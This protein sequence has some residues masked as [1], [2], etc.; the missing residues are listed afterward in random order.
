MD[1]ASANAAAGRL[2]ERCDRLAEFSDGPVG[3]TR[4]FLSPAMVRANMAL[5]DWMHAAGMEVRQDAAG[6]LIGRLRSA[7]P[8]AKVLLVGSHLDTV[9]NAGRYDGI[10]GVLAGLSLAEHFAGRPLPFHLDVV[11]FSEEEGVRF[12]TPYL[13]SAAV[14]GTFDPAWMQLQDGDGFTVEDVLLSAGLEPDQIPAA[15]YPSHG[16]LGFLELHI[17]QGP[18]LEG[19]ELPLGVV[20]AIIGQ[21]RL[22]LRFVGRSGHAGTTPMQGRR[23]AGVAAAQWVGRVRQYGGAVEGLRATIGRLNFFPGAR[24]VIPDHVEASLDVRHRSDGIRRR[25]VEDLLGEARHIAA[26]EGCTLE[27]LER[28]HQD[29]VPMDPALSELLVAG[30]E[31]CGVRTPLMDSG[32]GHDAAVLAP[33]F[34]A[35]MLFVR[36]PEGLSHHPLE[37]VIA[38]DVALALR[39][40]ADVTEKLAARYAVADPA[41]SQNPSHPPEAAP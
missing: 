19:A 7:K 13:G 37:A 16:V 33:R 28:A 38:S 30:A 31:R 18:V 36:S 32:A 1:A 15:A 9:P 17:E 21:E 5:E 23:D 6:N 34:P 27:V 22:A 10:L 20:G 26:A 24:N 11:A 4:T 3:I 35:A 25:S 12:R 29:A 8:N 39:V 2:L 40:L 14:A 41:A